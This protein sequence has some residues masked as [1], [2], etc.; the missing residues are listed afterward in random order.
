VISGS[1]PR[2]SAEE[3]RGYPWRGAGTRENR[4]YGLLL[5]A[6]GRLP[7]APTTP[8]RVGPDGAAGRVG[9]AADEPQGDHDASGDDIF[10]DLVERTDPAA[11]LS[12]DY[13]TVTDTRLWQAVHRIA[14]TKDQARDLPQNPGKDEDPRTEAFMDRHDYTENIQVEL[15]ALDPPEL[16][17]LYREAIDR[18]W[19]N[20]AYRAVLARED[21]ERKRF[22]PPSK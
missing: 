13:G 15:D 12:D 4:R 19:D 5:A 6:A 1:E 10:R 16:R 8:R 11:V 22:R 2:F 18:Y 17:R 7:G 3:G 9:S 14:L 21:E 20:D